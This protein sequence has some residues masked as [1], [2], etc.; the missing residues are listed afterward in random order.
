[1]ELGRYAS[2]SMGNNYVLIITVG[3][4]RLQTNVVNYNVN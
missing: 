1:M 2:I 3:N 4:L